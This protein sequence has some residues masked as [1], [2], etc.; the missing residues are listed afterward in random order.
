MVSTSQ[1]SRAS[2]TPPSVANRWPSLFVVCIGV[3]MAFINASSTIGALASIQDDLHVSGSTL[4]WVTSSF[5]L[6]LVSLVMS[7]GTFGE[8]YGRRRTYLVGVVLFTVGSVTAFAADS[9][10][11]LIT[12]QAIMGVGAAAILPSGLAIVSTSFHAPHERTGAISIWASCAGLGLAIGPLVAGFLLAHFSWHSVYLTNVVLGVIAIMLTLL[13]MKESKHPS[14]QL[15]P[16]GVVLGTITVAAATYAIIE[17]GARG[18]GEPPIVVAYVV[19]AVGAIAFLRVESTH[20][21]PMLDLRLFRS[22]SFTTVMLVGAAAMFG[23]VGI[24]LLSVLHLERVAGHDALG[25]GVRLMP[26]MV[27]YVVF[28]AFA[29]RIVRFVG[30]TVTLT[31]GLVLMGVG[32][33][34]LLWNGADNG[35][36]HMWPGLALAGIGSALLVAPSTAAAVNSV[37][38]LQAGMASATVNL[39]RQL[40]SMLGPAVLGTIATSRFPGL[41]ADDLGG[42]G[43]PADSAKSVA[44]AISHGQAP[45][46]D[47]AT[48]GLLS[49]A[50]PDAF[51]TAL[52]GGLLTGG[53]VLLVVAVLAALF[54]RHRHP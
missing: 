3:M 34:S 13:V 16:L 52:H 22:A 53:I 40:G 21:D 5:T 23:F 39:F 12:G 20:H 26:M 10:G 27:T 11:V 25:A 47:D 19:A 6:A 28:S 37:S 2:P 48:R 44:A 1:D 49:H 51:S 42:D 54:V 4:V 41:L 30:F 7:A 17:G 18:Y 38:P 33:L 50:V 9:S 24:A 15:D 29:A 36:S 45:T 46:V 35:Y 43:L 32:A 14:R 8:L 31:A